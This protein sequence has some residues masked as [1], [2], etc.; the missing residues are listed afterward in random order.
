MFRPI[1]TY[2]H[3]VELDP[4]FAL[5]WARMAILRSFLNFNAIDLNTYHA[6]FGQAGG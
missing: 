2:Q 4:N 1:A 3:A 6:R 5:A